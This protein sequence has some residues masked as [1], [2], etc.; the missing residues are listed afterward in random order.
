MVF[1]VEVDARAVAIGADGD[2][3][4]PV[5]GVGVDDQAAVTDGVVDLLGVVGYLAD[6]LVRT[7]GHGVVRPGPFGVDLFAQLG[8]DVHGDALGAQGACGQ[9]GVVRFLAIDARVKT[10]RIEC[11]PTYSAI[12]AP[13][14]R[15][16]TTT[17]YHRATTP[18]AEPEF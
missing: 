4:P 11:A 13:G 18:A 1:T 10:M 14:Q 17:E 7:P 6:L 5:V 16:S 2:G 9:F 15:T 8:R 3:G 12:S